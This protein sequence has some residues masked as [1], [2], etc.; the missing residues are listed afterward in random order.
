MKHEYVNKGLTNTNS[1]EDYFQDSNI[2]DRFSV[3]N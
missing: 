3:F 1:R 2:F